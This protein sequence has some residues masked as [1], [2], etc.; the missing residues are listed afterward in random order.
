MK[1]ENLFNSLVLNTTDDNKLTIARIIVGMIFISEGIQKLLIVSYMGPTMFKDAG[2]ENTMF[3]VNFTGA[4]EISCGILI[5]LG[6]L[7]RLASIPLLII[8][9]TALITTKLPLLTNKDFWTFAHGYN[10]EF[11]LTLLLIMLFIWGGGKWSVDQ[12]IVRSQ[13]T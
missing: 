2:F 4:F 12:K 10:V 13:Q 5:L 3:W 7:T 9:I 6:F 11:A 8:M 1:T